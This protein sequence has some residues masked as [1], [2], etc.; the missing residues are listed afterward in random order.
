MLMKDAIKQHEERMAAVMSASGTDEDTSSSINRD[1][2]VNMY[3]MIRIPDQP[4]AD[5]IFP[6]AATF[7]PW[8]TDTHRSRGAS[9]VLISQQLLLNK[10]EEERGCPD[11]GSTSRV[12]ACEILSR[13]AADPTSRA[14]RDLVSGDFI[15]LAF[16]N[17]PSTTASTCPTSVKNWL[18]ALALVSPHADISSGAFATLEQVAWRSPGNEWKASL[19]TLLVAPAYYGVTFNAL[20]LEKFTERMSGEGPDGQVLKTLS[21]AVSDA[22]DTRDRAGLD[23]G[24]N[25]AKPTAAANTPLAVVNLRMWLGAVKNTALQAKAVAAETKLHAAR[26]TANIESFSLSHSSVAS[27]VAHIILR[28]TTDPRTKTLRAYMM[29]AVAAIV[30]AVYKDEFTNFVRNMGDI[31]DLFEPTKHHHRVLQLAQLINSGTE[32]GRTLQGMF[33]RRAIKANLS[34][35]IIKLDISS[36]LEDEDINFVFALLQKTTPLLRRLE[37]TAEFY[38]RLYSLYSG[39]DLLLRNEECDPTIFPSLDGIV[40]ELKAQHSRIHHNTTRV[41]GVT[42]RLMLHALWRKLGIMQNAS[43]VRAPKKRQ[44]GI[45]TFMHSVK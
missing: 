28:M 32:R 7:V 31:L 20:R 11:V 10:T 9:H 4:L 15:P 14:V 1:G 13:A 6:L 21:Q 22:D 45:T 26:H 25:T 8:V 33:V 35:E 37:R 38:Y 30:A 2:H 12:S 36:I 40:T 27:F 42:L 44:S 3:K 34:C 18:L 29:E 41:D 24:I 39:I 17:T 43:T 23:G 16:A 5:N 19:R